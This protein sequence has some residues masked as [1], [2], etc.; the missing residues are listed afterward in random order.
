MFIAFNVSNKVNSTNTNESI[1]SNRQRLTLIQIDNYSVAS[2]VP[3]FFCLDKWWINLPI[4]STISITLRHVIFTSILQTNCA[5]THID[6][7]IFQFFGFLSRSLSFGFRQFKHNAILL[8]I[9]MMNTPN[10]LLLNYV[11]CHFVCPPNNRISCPKPHS[12][13]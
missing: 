7:V 1:Y 5:N 3:F 10:E 12:D 13:C 2:S 8:T 4:L 11:Y 9:D 6:F